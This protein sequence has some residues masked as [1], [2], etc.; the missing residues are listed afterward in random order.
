VRGTAILLP[1]ASDNASISRLAELPELTIR[2]LILGAII[3]VVFMASNI[4][5]GLKVG[6][7]FSSSIP[8]AVIS[9]AVLRFFRDSN[10]LENN[11]VQTQ[12]S[13]A[14][15]LSSIIFVLPGLIM[16]GYW[17]GFPFWQTAGICAIGGIL[18]VMYTIPL[19]RAMVV[20]TD[21]PYPEGVAAAEILRVG[22]GERDG[23][24]KAAAQIG[25][26]AEAGVGAIV[27]GGVTAGAFSLVSSG[28]HIFAEQIAWWFQVGASVFRIGTG[29]SLALLG[30]GYL[31]GIVVGIAMIVGV[32]IAW[33]IAVPILTAFTPV[34]LDSTAAKVAAGIWSNQVRFIGAGTIAVA[35]VWTLVILFKPLAEGTRSMLA[36]MHEIRAGRGH[37][38]PRTERDIPFHWVAGITLALIVPM[39]AIFTY[40]VDTTDLPIS[41]GMT[42]GLVA[43]AVAYAL[44]FGFLIA[45]VCG[46]MAGLIGS[47]NSPI[48]GIGIIAIA[49]V[50]LLLLAILGSQ[51][52]LLGD[53]R[54]NKLAIAIAIF[55]TSVVLAIATISNDNLQDLK[56]GLLVGATPWRQQVA[57]IVGCICGALVISPILDLLYNAYGFAGALP[58]PD[59][60]PTQAL[61]APQATLMSAIAVGILSHKLDWTMVL[62]GL[63]TGIVL[64][65]FD[66]FL[67]R[68]PGVAR[69]PVLA[70]GIGIY[71]PPTVTVTVAIG[72]F[73][74]WLID[75]ALRRNAAANAAD[76]E[77]LAARPRRRGVLIAS[78]LIVGESLIGVLM[79]AIIGATGDQTPLALVG[80]DFATTA[81]WLGLLAFVAVCL[82][83][84]YY[85]LQG[86]LR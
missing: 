7:T 75:R 54:A 14:G 71:L 12:A 78:G 11:M 39:A 24:T 5:L 49:L 56:T 77:T 51:P 58:R 59:M 82:G 44:L 27:A 35:A 76:F 43:F 18:G 55:I 13:A 21:L 86:E 48:S 70:V 20:E 1:P 8:A 69:L 17:N 16:I 66:E 60:D 79:A 28:F 15:T 84:Y 64:I 85:V 31:V 41:A 45:A 36:S 57:L 80:P 33:G 61:A 74:G 37:A 22:S 42:W 38:I 6:L 3:T 47:S 4:Y 52:G 62:I 72:A 68:R 2:G 9:M 67:R 32:V 83:F 73:L 26:R 50:S 65:L 23:S 46:Y 19:R 30:A 40:F 63:A 53:P 25:E 29:F 81:A 10:V 34:P